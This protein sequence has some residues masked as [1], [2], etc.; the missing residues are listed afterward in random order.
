[1]RWYEKIWYGKEDSIPVS[2]LLPFSILYQWIIH[3]RRWLYQKKI[4]K[5]HRLSKPV[6]VVGNLTL[7]G[8]GKTPVVIALAHWLKERGERPGIISRGYGRKNKNRSLRVTEHSTATDVGDEALV[9]ARQTQVPVIVD[10]N[11]VRGGRQLI[12][13]FNCTIIISDDG[14]QH[15]ALARDIEILVI[16][17][18][19]GFGNNHLFPAGPLRESTERTQ[20][21]DFIISN[22]AEISNGFCMNY[23]YGEIKN[24]VHPSMTLQKENASVE[25]FAFAGLGNPQRFFDELDRR[26]FKSRKH[27]FPDHYDFTPTDFAFTDQTSVVMTEKDAVK[28]QGFAQPNWWYLPISARLPAEFWESLAQ[29][30]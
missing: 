14:L 20:Q 17:G 26:G 29:K 16:D 2:L 4:L 12:D 15:T 28:C 5:I 13:E 30:L 9:I 22:G 7:G 24:L 23:E 8:T 10:A 3:F 19:R 11:R 6:I 27:S 25:V 18:L 1:M 21:V